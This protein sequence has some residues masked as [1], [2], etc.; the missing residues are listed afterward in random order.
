MFL[1]S[2][3][4]GFSLAELIVIIAIL[5]V[6]A[7]ILAPSLLQYTENSRA[8]KD[9]SAMDEVVN[10][11]Q[12][13]LADE[14]CF[15]EALKYSCTNNYLTYSDSS[16]NYGQQINDGEFWAPDG[17]GRAT[18]ITFNPEY[19]P[20]NQIIY[21]L[22]KGIVNDMTYGNGSVAADRIMQGALVDNN[23]CY[24]NKLPQVYNT[25]KQTVGTDVITTSQTYRN[26][27]F[28]IF[29]KFNQK[30]STTVADVSGSFNGT[31][32]YEGANAASGSGTSEY[33]SNGDA[34]TTVTT[35]G[36]STPNY[37][38]SSLNGT[39]SFG[40]SANINNNIAD[41]QQPTYI[42]N[43]QKENKCYYYST[44]KKA[45]DDVNNNTMGQNGDSTKEDAVAFVYTE[46]GTNYVVLLKDHTTN[47]S[48]E[49]TKTMTV[50]LGGHTISGS[51][52]ILSNTSSSATLTIDG[53]ISGSTITST[54]T[55]A[56]NGVCIYNYGGL[57]VRGGTYNLICES[58]QKGG[59]AIASHTNSTFA[60]IKEAV[61]NCS[62]TSM[63]MFGIQ[64]KRNSTINGCTITLSNNKTPSHTATI[65]TNLTTV[66]VYVLNDGENNI[67]TNTQITTM[68][69]EGRYIS[70]SDGLDYYTGSICV[71]VLG[72]SE[73]TI[74][75]CE[76][77]SACVGLQSQGGN[78]SVRDTRITGGRSVTTT[79]QTST[80]Y[81]ENCQLS[82]DTSLVIQDVSGTAKAAMIIRDSNIAMHNCTINGSTARLYVESSST[83]KISQ[84]TF[85]NINKFTITG[86][87]VIYVGTRNNLPS[88]ATPNGTTIISTSETYKK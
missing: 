9:E 82:R 4:K 77:V 80:I 56:T 62:G 16:G 48:I 83:L 71:F 52:K 67:I 3:N 13:A 25:V 26:S 87:S 7:A 5:A 8:Q 74:S 85:T 61:I 50:V 66:G 88:F 43:I 23:Q 44:L 24:F 2:K 37:T 81:F 15:D 58:P 29:I 20:N 18:T 36:S 55:A 72:N 75:N 10:A 33:D 42:E 49:T 64:A 1:K 47:E 78:V 41:Y 38:S 68:S 73:A 69:G 22:S 35:P 30:D 28:T 57:I 17:S 32:L 76:L 51:F 11:V 27:S 84:S 6:F 54:S 14:K 70:D 45:I 21:N 59:A 34:I 60:D 39:G 86:N 31:N 79:T 40:G 53:R 65:D 12:L 19:G 46:D 63:K